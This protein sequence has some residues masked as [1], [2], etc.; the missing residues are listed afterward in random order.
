MLAGQRAEERCRR[1][2]EQAVCRPRG[3]QL[4][5]FKEQEKGLHAWREV[6]EETN[7]R[8]FIYSFIGYVRAVPEAEKSEDGQLF[9]K[10]GRER[11]GKK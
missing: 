2:R 7:V 1:K 10:L 8:S 4:G 11:K 3:Q 5:R 9:Q 6:N